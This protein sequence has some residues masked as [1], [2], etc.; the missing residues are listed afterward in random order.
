MSI[1]YSSSLRARSIAE[2]LEH[3]RRIARQVG[4]SRVT[5]TTR[6][7][8]IG[9]PVFASI[10]PTAVAGSLCV[11][12]GKGMSL[13]E[14]RIG[15]YMEG[16]ELAY[17]EP[18]RNRLPI[19]ATKASQILDGAARSGAVYDFA[20]KLR[21]NDDTLIPC[22]E[23]RDIR[24]DQ[25]FLVPAECV[26][27]PLMREQGGGLFGSDGNGLCSGNTVEEATLHGLAEVLE[28]DITSFIFG[29][30]RN[31][32]LVRQETLPTE[33]RQL[34]TRLAAGGFDLYVR[35]AENSFGLPYFM[36]AVNERD[37]ENA[38]HRGD[39]CHPCRSIALTRAV[40]EAMQSRLTD[41]HGGRDDLSIHR[42]RERPGDDH[43]DACR[44]FV[45][46]LASGE[47]V[48]YLRIPDH[49]DIARDIP[50]ALSF[51][52][53]LLEGQGFRHILR[54]VLSPADL[55]ISVVRVVVPRLECHIGLANRVGQRLKA[56]Y[57]QARQADPL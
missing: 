51:L 46:A 50:S 12:A 9:V 33:I 31:T 17:A 41:I 37:V 30:R 28:R 15:A 26:V 8:R 14:A 3:A 1:A 6:L 24:S 29:V 43:P 49:S 45:A 19:I 10:R 16:I 25:T 36:A 13:E 18:G 47:P 44:R 21:I 52:L 20:P 39:G 23:A 48:D 34:A 40:C 27:F 22:V 2:T 38:A 35:Y 32:R 7:D 54:V 53:R 57:E 4:I 55:P 11:S 5:D 42:S 56:A